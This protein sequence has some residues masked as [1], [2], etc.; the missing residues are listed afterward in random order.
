MT[1]I[2]F[3]SVSH[4]RSS[5]PSAP[6]F[7]SRQWCR[8]HCRHPAADVKVIYKA[9]IA[10][11]TH[12]VFTDSIANLR[13][14]FATLYLISQFLHVLWVRATEQKLKI[15]SCLLSS[16]TRLDKL[17]WVISCNVATFWMLT[18]TTHTQRRVANVDRLLLLLLAALSRRY[19]CVLSG[20][21][22]ISACC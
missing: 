22:W 5:F 18:T 20:L 13:K 4:C 12:H 17:L 15:K 21:F 1:R 9:K 11:S 7:C 14:L 19:H 6:C 8:C 2:E 16:W 3:G 10:A